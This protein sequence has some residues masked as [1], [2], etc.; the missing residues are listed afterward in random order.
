M[1]KLLSLCLLVVVMAGC[2]TTGNRTHLVLG[3]GLF[4]VQSTNQVT[5]VKT[6]TLGLHAGGGRLNVGLSR[7]M[8]VSIPTNSDTILEIK[9]R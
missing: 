4:R 9:R 5:V 8:T 6:S 3:L 7:G 1:K 2:S